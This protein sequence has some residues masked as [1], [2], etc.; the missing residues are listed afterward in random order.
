[1]PI[2]DISRLPSL[3]A[4]L[5]TWQGGRAAATL[6]FPT[7]SNRPWGQTIPWHMVGAIAAL[8]VMIAIAAW[9]FSSEAECSCRRAYPSLGAGCRFHES[10]RRPDF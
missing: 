10:H 9:Y 4:D 7:S 6:Q 3:S 5:E 8:V 2:C 1:M